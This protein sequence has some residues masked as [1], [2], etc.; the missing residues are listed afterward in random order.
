[1]PHPFGD[2]C[3]G[4]RVLVWVLP[5]RPRPARRRLTREDAG[6]GIECAGW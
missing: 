3:G 2:F 6:R 1:M 5:W 4:G